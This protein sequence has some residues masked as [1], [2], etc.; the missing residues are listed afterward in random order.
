MD[1]LEGEEI[2]SFTGKGEADIPAAAAG[3]PQTRQA[4]TGQKVI[5]I[6]SMRAELEKRGGE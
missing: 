2:V 5:D 3:G 1:G 6:T 4:D